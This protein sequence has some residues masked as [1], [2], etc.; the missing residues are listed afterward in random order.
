MN[1]QALRIL[2]ADDEAANRL[3]LQTILEKQGFDV[4][5]AVNGEEAV[6]LFRS[7]Q[8][9][10]VLMDIKMPVMDGYQA[11]REIKSL[12]ADRFVPIIFLTATTEDEGLVK[13]I[14]SGGD[15]FLTKPYS[16]VLLRA[17]IDAFMRIRNLY[18]TVQ[19]QHQELVNH[20]ERLERERQ[21][22][23][24]VFSNIMGS[25]ALDLSIIKSRISPLSLFS[26]DIILAAPKPSGGIHVLLGDFSGHGLAA[27]TGALP[28]SSVFYSMTEKGFS[29][30]EIVAEINAKLRVILPEGMFLAACM[31]N[32]DP[33]THTMS[34]WNGGI[35][36]VFIYSESGDGSVRKI[37]PDNLPLGIVDEEK[38]NR[39]LEV[40]GMHEGDRVYITSDG[41]TETVSPEGKF[42]GED[43]LVG[44]LKENAKPEE[45]FDIICNELNQFQGGGS[46][47]DDVAFIEIEYQQAILEATINLENICEVNT[48]TKPSTWGFSMVLGADLMQHFD[49]LP[50]IM[51][52]LAELQGF[53]GRRQE[54]FTVFSELFSNA[55]E[56]GILKLDSAMKK[57]ANGFAEYYQE[58]SARLGNLQEGEIRIDIQHRPVDNGGELTVRF[59]DTGEGFD[60]T[61]RLPNLENNIEYSGRGIQLLHS[62]CCDIQYQGAGNIAEVTYRWQ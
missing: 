34:V 18:G 4:L 3:I 57:T 21:L 46:Q 20:Q 10:L 45:F 61:A 14:E 23:K 27:A 38:F 55:L 11:A 25:G 22:A 36:A 47:K 32:M 15:D 13:C 59:E 43:N 12:S 6:A 2:V 62:R 30:G 50:V 31:I 17:R 42:F 19:E 33:V 28:V 44:I 26:G 54:L 7:E 41:V 56:H 40:V 1:I 48:A 39:H 51:Q 37:K 29:V 8:P 60:Y 5:T 35:P 58:R 52:S 16:T 9:D 49:P 53:G 24:R